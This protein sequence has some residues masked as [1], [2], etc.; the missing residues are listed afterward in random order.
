VTDPD[1]LP[2]LDAARVQEILEIFA[3]Y[4][5]E[6]HGRLTFEAFKQVVV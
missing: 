3:A 6:G 2:C 1:H 5:I 4:D